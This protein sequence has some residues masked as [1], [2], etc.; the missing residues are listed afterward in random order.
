MK[1]IMLFAAVLFAFGAL[2]SC[3][4]SDDWEILKHPIHVTGT[5][6]PQYGVPVASGEMNINDLLSSLSSDYSGYL[7]NDEVV[8]VQYDTSL[9]D[10]IYASSLSIPSSK[11]LKLRGAKDAIWYSKDTTLVD[12]IDIDFFNDVTV[13]GNINI[14]HIWVNLGV[15]A[16]GECSDVVKPYVKARFENLSIKYEDHNGVLKTFSGVSVGR[17]DIDDISDGF[18]RHFDSIDVKD[19]AN[20]MPRRI[21][22]SYKMKFRVS[23]D[24]VS[25]NMANMTYAEILDSVQM[26]RLIY[27][28]NLNVSMPLSIEFNN[29]TFSYD[30]NLGDGLS[31]V[32]LDSIINSISPVLDVDIER[33][34]MRMVLD[35]GIPLQF[36]LN[37]S[38]V[39]A[40][41]SHLVTLFTN[42][43]VA[44]ALVGTN[45]ANP[46]QYV[47][48]QDKE[49]TL[50]AVLDN[51][52]IDKLSKA[53]ILKVVLKT[54]SNNKHVAIRRSDY[55]KVRAYLITKPSVNIDAPITNGG[56]L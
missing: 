48:I 22:A 55:L 2:T 43:T 4:R 10:T 56:I 28:A 3:L 49:T 18:E 47:A 44:S 11:T 20:D 39:D 32:N 33:T 31:Q 30:V 14:E 53:K 5:L 46:A 26:T 15:R 23:S 42:A 25:D 40:Q 45:P 51:N 35:N 1:K 37:A 6:S 52:D 36:T 8:T 21:I 27:A 12:T 7:S 19:I 34:R 13:S 17:I 24:L 38:L 9:S 50:E 41:G 29:L 54:D 16:Y